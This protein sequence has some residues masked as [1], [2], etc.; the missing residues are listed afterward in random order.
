MS[1]TDKQGRAACAEWRSPSVLINSRPEIQRV[2]DGVFAEPAGFSASIPP[3]GGT[4]APYKL[5]GFQ[6]V[7]VVLACR[8]DQ[9]GLALRRECTRY[10]ADS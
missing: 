5:F 8:D 9:A 6:C 2:C 4:T 7:R 10:A 3:S 1:K